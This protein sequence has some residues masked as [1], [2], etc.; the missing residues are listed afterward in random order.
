MS[1]L[2]W[3]SVRLSGKVT[4]P[5]PDRAVNLDPDPGGKYTIIL[6]KMLMKTSS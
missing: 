5:D 6:K 1:N 3:I 2:D 4:D